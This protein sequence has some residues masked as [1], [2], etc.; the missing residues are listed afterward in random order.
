MSVSRSLSLLP[1]LA[2]IVAQAC[3]GCAHERPWEQPGE[4]WRAVSSDHFV[5]Y[6]ERSFPTYRYYLNRLEDTY[7]GLSRAFFSGVEVPRVEVLLLS[8][9]DYVARFRP[10]TAGV[11]TVSTSAPGGLLVLRESPHRVVV[12]EVAAHELVHRFIEARYPSMP[13]WLNE[14]IASYLE[15]IRVEGGEVQVGRLSALID[16]FKLSDLMPLRALALADHQTFH[17]KDEKAMYHSATEFVRFLLRPD[18]GGLEADRWSHMVG[19]YGVG[20]PRKETPDA[21]LKRVDPTLDWAGL[22]RQVAAHSETIDNGKKYPIWVFPFV[23]PPRA[24][25]RVE[26]ADPRY[27]KSLCTALAAN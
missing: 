14:G 10:E 1:T 12:H 5:L 6:T 7:A 17:G 26:P 24:D 9:E 23:P 21:V 11:F 15:T 13:V 16:G 4:R 20:G 3:G 2:L 27:I 18:A 25:L 19:V 8:D 22:Q